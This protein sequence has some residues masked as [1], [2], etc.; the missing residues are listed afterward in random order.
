ME[1]KQEKISLKVIGAIIATGILAF[2]GVLVETAMNV[3]FP[4]LSTEF[5]VTTATVQWL[6]TSYL[7]ILAIIVPL[8]GFLKRSFT[9]KQLFLVSIG[10]FSLGLMVDAVAPNFAILL[11]GRMFQG[12]G[13]G[14]S[15]PLMFNIILEQVPASKIGLMM[16]V[17]NMIPAIAPAIGPTFGGLVV[18][19]I[20]WRYIFILL[21]PIMAIALI[22]G[23]LTIEQKNRVQRESFDILSMLAITLLFVGTIFGF[24]NMGSTDFLS[25]GVAGAFAVGIIG[26]IMLVTR[27]SR[28]ENP[29]LRLDLLKNGT[30]RSHVICFF[31]IQLVLMGLVFILP[32]Y[33]QLVN[34]G[35]AQV[36]GLVVLPGATLGAIFTP[37]G[38]RILD[39][40]GA[41]RPITAG[42]LIILSALLLFVTFSG[43]L[44]N[45]MVGVLYFL[46][47][48]GISFS[49]GNL[50]TNGLKQLGT[51]EQADGN[52]IIMTLQQFAGAAGTSIIAGIISQNQAD[53]SLTIAQGTINGARSSFIFLTVLFL[54][55]V[56]FLVRM[57]FFSKS[58][59]K[60][61]GVS[62][63]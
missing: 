44:S 12:I 47:T 15:L 41:K 9:N 42:S 4:T 48:V 14:I 37:I 33:I 56:F 11:L 58:V 31:I 3:T 2:C 49:M 20:G 23:L 1:H 13:T 59:V 30:Y 32:N 29:I 10:F 7:L 60:S 27:S 34:G 62:D 24:S 40:F 35:S 38:G 39:R 54:V 26:L 36:S 6:T 21:L 57:F 63:L 16:G 55:E 50:M 28:I 5:S 19:G 25:V 8:S 52:A 46:F 61:P 45:L 22:L 53:Q 51:A 17:G 43:Q 18:T